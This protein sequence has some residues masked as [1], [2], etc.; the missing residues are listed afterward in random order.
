[1]NIDLDLQVATSVKT[2]PHPSQIRE[3]VSHTLQ[4]RVNSAEITIRM[5]DFEESA[6]LNE[7]YRKKKGATNVLSFP[8][9]VM[10]NMD[11]ELVGDIIICA[12]IVEAEAE[13]QNKAILAHWAH[14]VIHGL[15]HLLGFDHHNDETA[16][17][18]ESLE[19]EIL[20]HLGFPPPYGDTFLV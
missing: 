14:M 20:V 10:P 7:R 6:Q 11:V 8:Y 3:W 19:T 15:L 4:D 9:H 13:E 2:L 17:E 18:M 5:V 16:N 1:M 12:P